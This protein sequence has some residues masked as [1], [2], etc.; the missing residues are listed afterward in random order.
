MPRRPLA[1]AREAR[2]VDELQLWR[3]YF[4]ARDVGGRELVRLGKCTVGGNHESNG[5]WGSRLVSMFNF[6]FST[7]TI[8]LF[9]LIALVFMFIAFT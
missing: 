4:V 5:K 2:F 8:A 1:K 3:T 7:L 6:R 9:T